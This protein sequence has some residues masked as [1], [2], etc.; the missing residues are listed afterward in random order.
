M[1]RRSKEVIWR[2]KYRGVL[3][4]GLLASMNVTIFLFAAKAGL[5]CI[6]A[7]FEQGVT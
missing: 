6:V 7:L 3:L 5:H 4:K 2:D 1:C